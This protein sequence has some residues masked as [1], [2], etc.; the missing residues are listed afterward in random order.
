MCSFDSKNYDDE[1]DRISTKEKLL[2]DIRSQIISIR[3]GLKEDLSALAQQKDY[4]NGILP[5]VAKER[6]VGDSINQG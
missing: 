4:Y 6:T 2:N 1:P 3:A 5:Q